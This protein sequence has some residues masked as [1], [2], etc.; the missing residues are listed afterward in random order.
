V[1]AA[2]GGANAPSGGP[3]RGAGGGGGATSAAEGGA[4]APSGGPTRGAGGGGGATSAARVVCTSVLLLGLGGCTPAPATPAAS[5]PSAKATPAPAA[6][7]RCEHAVVQAVCPK[8]NPRLA[9]VFQAKGDWCAEHGFPESFCPLCHPERG[10]APAAPVASDGAPENGTVVRLKTPE[11][12][13]VAG[14]RTEAVVSVPGGA[15]LTANATLAFDATRRA[16]VNVR[17]P[18]V[19]RAVLVD[20]GAEVRAGD[21]LAVVESAAATADQGRR[22]A[23]EARLRVAEASF[24]RESRLAATGAAPRQSAQAAEAEL[25]AARAEV[26]AVRAGLGLLGT[27]QA[28]GRTAL[29]SPIAGTVLRREAALG[30]MVGPETLLFEVVDTRTLW[31]EIDLPE[32]D[33]GRVRNGQAV[34]LRFGEGVDLP[35]TEGTVQFVSPEID[36]HTRTVRAR[37]AVPNPEGRLR[38]RM[39]AQAEIA[40][41][42]TAPAVRLPRAA[43]QRAQ[44]VDFVFVRTE[45]NVYE[46]R[47]VE[48]AGADP[49]S[50]DALCVRSG[51]RPGDAVVT[52]GSFLLKTET[53]KSSIGAGCCDDD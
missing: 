3:T 22:L 14:L 4:N 31:A 27:P 15:R 43:A 8:C 36:P 49:T 1:S 12:D 34:T 38:A 35:A 39:F 52:E 45:P 32:R 44:N 13:A 25:E 9:P 41:G 17:T 48:L 28:G 23:A 5:A 6:A 51:L 42:E 30:R 2:E 16:E 18:G 10:G 47:R 19:L 50:P 37:A 46:V 33:A 29:T 21:T 40:L 20:V 7:G 53:L 11:D 24:E 26:A